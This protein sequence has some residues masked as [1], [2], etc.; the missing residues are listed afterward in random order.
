MRYVVYFLILNVFVA[1]ICFYPNKKKSYMIFALLILSYLNM[2]MTQP[3]N[4][5]KMVLDALPGSAETFIISWYAYFTDKE[6]VSWPSRG[7]V[8]GALIAT[9]MIFIKNINDIL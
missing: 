1:L 9:T 8:L 3:L 5:G 7:W 2:G 4:G 6:K